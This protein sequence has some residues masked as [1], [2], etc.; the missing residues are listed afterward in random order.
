MKDS[1]SPEG[2]QKGATVGLEAWAPPLSFH[3]NRDGECLH[4]LP[5]SETTAE[6]GW[7]VAKLKMASQLPR[8]GILFSSIYVRR[9]RGE[10][11]GKE[12]EAGF[13]HSLQ[14]CGLAEDGWA[15]LAIT[16]QGYTSWPKLEAN[17]NL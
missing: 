16:V 4:F 8:I 14:L 6:P 7:R 9:K 10:Q 3:S 15:S 11:G 5:V 1:L 12:G 13:G 17:L 2:T